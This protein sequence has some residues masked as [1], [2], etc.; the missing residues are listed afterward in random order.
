MYVTG[1]GNHVRGIG[2]SHLEGGGGGGVLDSLGQAGGEL[3]FPAL[4]G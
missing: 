1:T 3:V 2:E 4:E